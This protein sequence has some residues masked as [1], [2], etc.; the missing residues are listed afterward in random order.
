MRS[1]NH[2]ELLRQIQ[3]DAVSSATPVT[4][5]LRRCQVL[6]ARLDLPELG[7]WVRYELNGY[8]VEAELPEYRVFSGIA[9]GHFLGPFGSGLRNAVLPAGNL[10][11]KFRDWARSASLR[12]P[13]VALEEVANAESKS[14]VTLPWPGDLIA[15]VQQDFYDH[16]ALGQ[17][18]LE[19]SRADFVSA[20][21]TVRNRV[22]TFAL[23]AEPFVTDVA[24]KP[25]AH[26]A[27]GLSQ[28]FHTHIYGTVGNIAQGSTGVSQ[29]SVNP[30]GD[31]QALLDELQRAG[32]AEGDL[33]ALKLAIHD[34]GP[35]QEDH[36]GEKV[37]AWLGRMFSKAMSGVWNVTKGTATTVLPKLIERYYGIG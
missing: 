11:E 36:F 22:L 1:M 10:P 6:A 14:N 19:V 5:L 13:I 23:E 27:D 18:W 16:M 29:V 37:A 4:E 2:L 32:V 34:D 7:E 20:V 17:A 15:H 24:G 33:E 25:T 12:Q 21:E 35:P 31:L 26:S 9:K 8:P 3:A 28:V 30:V